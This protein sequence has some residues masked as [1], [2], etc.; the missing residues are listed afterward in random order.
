MECSDVQDVRVVVGDGARGGLVASYHGDAGEDD[1][2]G[3]GGDEWFL[4]VEAVLDEDY[5]R[6][7]WCDGG[8]DLSG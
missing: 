3:V 1:V 4:D 6:D 7:A 2:L 8:S 5:Y